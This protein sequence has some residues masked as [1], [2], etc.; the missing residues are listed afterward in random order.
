[1]TYLYILLALAAGVLLPIQVGV[2]NSLR[3]GV[4]TPL[5]AAL[6][7]F[8]VGSACL[9]AYTLVVRAPWP[10]AATL[11]GLPSWSWMG[12]ALGAFYVAASIL[13]AQ[14]L[15]AAN[16]IGITV[17]AQLLTSLVLDH[18]GAIGYAQHDINLWRIAGALLMIAGAVLILKN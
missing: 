4:G 2:N 12:G 1:M 8:V 6:I 3:A 7:S 9:L 16:L 10:S 13:A 15:G 11:A 18:Y 17:A 14:K 5:I